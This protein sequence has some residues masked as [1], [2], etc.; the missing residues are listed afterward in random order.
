MIIS[1]EST[2]GDAGWGRI[3]SRRF[4]WSI[5]APR[6]RLTIPDPALPAMVIMT[7]W[8]KACVELILPISEYKRVTRSEGGGLTGHYERS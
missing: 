7:R 1:R 8:C 5:S 3:R 6:A 2:C 4:P